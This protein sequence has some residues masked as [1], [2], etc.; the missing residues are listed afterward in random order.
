MASL[1]HDLLVGTL[2]RDGGV[3]LQR[4]LYQAIQAA[5]LQR[6]LPVNH[7]LPSTRALAEQLLV[8]RLTV[9]LAYDRLLDEGYLYARPGSGTFVADTLPQVKTGVPAPIRPIRRRCRP[10]ARRSTRA[11]ARWRGPRAPSWAAYRTPTCFRFISGSACT[12]AT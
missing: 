12:T 1:L 8:S 7:K 3:T 6:R 9:S 10:G 11:S 4:Q 5:I 2:D